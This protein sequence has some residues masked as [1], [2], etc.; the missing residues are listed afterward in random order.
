MY[1][2]GLGYASSGELVVKQFRDLLVSRALGLTNCN[3][4]A[5]KLEVDIFLLLLL[6]LVICQKSGR[7]LNQGMLCPI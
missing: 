1:K 2:L 6:C 4:L 5:L 7:G 3:N